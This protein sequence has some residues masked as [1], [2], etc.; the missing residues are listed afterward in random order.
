M[1]DFLAYLDAL[2]VEAF[3]RYPFVLWP[4]YLMAV[5]VVRT[6]EGC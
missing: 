3:L 1:P 5:E 6:V 2:L 4:G